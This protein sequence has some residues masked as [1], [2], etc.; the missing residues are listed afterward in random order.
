[1]RFLTIAATVAV[2]C[3]TATAVFAEP[4]HLSDGQF[5]AANRCLGLMSSKTLATPDAATLATYLKTQESGRQGFVYDRADQAR[6]G[7]RH[8]ASRGGPE[9]LMHLTAER[10]GVCHGF[11][12]DAQMTADASHS[13]HSS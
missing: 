3:A 7:G 10:D 9:N 8:D 6:D 2:A 11:V 1:M 4:V 12:S 13:A 5:I